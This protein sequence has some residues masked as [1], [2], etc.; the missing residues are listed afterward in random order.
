MNQEL[1]HNNVN[2][3][4]RTGDAVGADD[5]AGGEGR[6]AEARNDLAQIYAAADAILDSIRMGDSQRFLDQ[7]RQSGGE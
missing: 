4:L 3:A 6:L 2:D 1:Q 7:V 5:P